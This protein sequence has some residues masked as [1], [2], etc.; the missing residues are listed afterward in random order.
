MIVL[1]ELVVLIERGVDGRDLMEWV[2]LHSR[3][4]FGS[5]FLECHDLKDAFSR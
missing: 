2:T 3:V 4:E 5:R 1:A